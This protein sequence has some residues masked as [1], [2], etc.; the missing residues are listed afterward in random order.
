MS[1][2]RRQLEESL[3]RIPT[4]LQNAMLASPLIDSPI[5][6]G[7]VIGQFLSSQVGFA[8]E[9]W[10]HPSGGS[11]WACIFASINEIQLSCYVNEDGLRG[12]DM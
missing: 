1:N 6:T 10:R 8:G 5:A 9:T 11:K 7:D 2:F 12:A 4:N 3:A